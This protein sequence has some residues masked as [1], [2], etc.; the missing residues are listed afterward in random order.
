VSGE[1]EMGEED[2][3]DKEDN[4]LDL[5]YD[6]HVGKKSKATRKRPPSALEDEAVY[7]HHSC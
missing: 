3:E 4:E 7:V 5:E 2:E 6:E 1:E